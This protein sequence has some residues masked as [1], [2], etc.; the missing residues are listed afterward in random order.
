MVDM[1]VPALLLAALLIV[2]PILGT[3]A[4]FKVR[5][6]R[7]EVDDLRARLAGPAPGASSTRSVPSVSP[8]PARGEA[9][10]PQDDRE[11]EEPSQ[12]EPIGDDGPEE[13][14]AV[15]T[16]PTGAAAGGGRLE[17]TV[18]AKWAVWVGGLALALG[19]VFLVRYSI[20]QGL[21]GPG[22]RIV[23]GLLFAAALCASGEWTRRRGAAFSVG[24]FEAANIPAILTAAG[25]LGAFATIYAAYQLYGF[26]PPAVA[27]IALGLVAVA[28]MVAALLHG[29]LLAALGIVGS[30]LVPFLTS[31][32]EPNAAGLGIYAFAVSIAAFGV[33]R[34]RLWRW[35]AVIAALGLI[36]FGALLLVVATAGE[37]PIVGIYVI[38]AWAAVFYVFVASLYERSP[39]AFPANDRIAVLMLSLVLLLALGFVTVDTDAATV[40]GL[41]L[42][43]FVPFASAFYYPA[44]RLIVPVAAIVSIVGYAGWELSEESWAPLANGFDALEPVDPNILPGYQQKMLSL[45]GALGFALAL[46]AGAMG[47]FGA[48]RSAARVPL[49]FGGAFV[50][51]LVLAI[52]YARTDFLDVSVR[53][54]SIALVLSVAFYAVALFADRRL[55]DDDEG[56]AG[57]TA[58]YLVAALSALTL[59]LCMLLERGVLT[60]AL[61][62]MAPATAYVYSHRPL[63]ALRPLTLV[64]AILWAARIAWDP[65]IVGGSLGST[66]VFNWL[67]YGYGVPAA[68]FV[69]AAWLLGR[70][71]R[72]RWLEAMEAIAVAVVTA[73]VAIVGLHAL[74]P[75]AVFTPIETLPEAAL[76]VLVGGGVALGLLQFRLTNASST[77]RIAADVLGYAGMAIAVLCLLGLYNP[78]LTGETIGAG[79]VF[80][81]LAFSYLLPGLLYGA[82]GYRGAG[83]RPAYSMAAF[84]VSGVLLFAWVSLSIRHWF[85]PEGLDIGPTGDPELYTYSAAWLA[86]G[87]AILSAGMAS[88][89]RM[90]RLLSAV[91]IV[92][93]VAKV[94]VVDMS[95]LTG[96]LR[97]LSFIGL[98]AVLVAIGLVYQRLL[99]RQA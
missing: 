89:I 64:P 17:E 96:F 22:A 76:L 21:L 12:A 35:L 77:L 46:L 3:I 83:I 79:V 31:S 26:L 47:L 54:G 98:G 11:A 7:R 59:G 58:S 36:F 74:D 10:E 18:G 72:D 93:V 87:I 38:A 78:L 8:W 15:D 34:L 42:L 82:L 37:R 25:T 55:A 4:F 20:E 69:A 19:A 51:L 60:V 68:G 99:R 94:F 71:H 70:Q 33:G 61:A 43:I 88:G 13:D 40:V 29:P 24:G 66:P 45:F 53:F 39:V 84:S 85:H 9:A 44:M 95:N 67:L 14:V 41:M 63:A 97:A 5:T 62:L 80:N 50:P 90:L 86:I 57:V 91:I 92:A 73:A 2:G 27:F 23:A 52:C 32:Q 81:K 48:M 75:G 30:Y 49:A 16:A 65:A 28:T 6:L 56:G 1:V